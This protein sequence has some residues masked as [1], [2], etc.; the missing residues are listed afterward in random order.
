M[1]L[2]F[3]VFVISSTKITLLTNFVLDRLYI[4]TEILANL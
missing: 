4:H 2:V 1:K 3:K